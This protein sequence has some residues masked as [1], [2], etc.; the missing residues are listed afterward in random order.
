MLDDVSIGDDVLLTVS[1]TLVV[2]V[3]GD[4]DAARMMA[5]AVAVVAEPLRAVADEPP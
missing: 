2:V 4:D 1:P 5:R 3:I